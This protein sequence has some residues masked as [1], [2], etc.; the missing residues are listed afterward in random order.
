MGI[1]VPIL[2]REAAEEHSREGEPSRDGV[3]LDDHLQDEL[4]QDEHDEVGLQAES[5][6]P[7]G[8]EA[9]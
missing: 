3:Q 5:A 2:K 7:T 9:C 6:G 1:S 4:R 8:P